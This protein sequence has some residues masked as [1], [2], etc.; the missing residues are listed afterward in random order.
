MRV[1]EVVWGGCQP[2]PW[3]ND[4]ILTPHTT[5]M[6]QILGRCLSFMA[7]T[8]S[9]KSM[10]IQRLQHLF[11]LSLYQINEKIMYTMQPYPRRNSR[12][13]NHGGAVCRDSGMDVVN[14]PTQRPG[15]SSEGVGWG[16]FMRVL[17]SLTMRPRKKIISINNGFILA[18]LFD[19]SL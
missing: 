18:L 12:P 4:M 14:Q 16:W 7:G 2:Q 9:N 8:K 6:A 10:L 11:L 15:A 17:L 5:Q 1:W 3:C 19:W 13:C